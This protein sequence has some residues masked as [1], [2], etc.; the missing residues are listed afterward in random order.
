MVCWLLCLMV[1]VSCYML[2]CLVLSEL[3]CC[4]GCFWCCMVIFLVVCCRFGVCR[5]RLVIC[6]GC[7]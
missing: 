5:V 1:R 3:M 6:G 2:V 4:V 7:V